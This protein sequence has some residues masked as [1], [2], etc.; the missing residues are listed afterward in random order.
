L[1]SEEVDYM[2]PEE[3]HDYMYPESL[4]DYVR[5]KFNLY[6]ETDYMYPEDDYMYPEPYSTPVTPNENVP[7]IF[8]YHKYCLNYDILEDDLD[9]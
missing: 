4:E 7:E 1:E 2:Y 8:N 3:E 5:F 9:V 6:P